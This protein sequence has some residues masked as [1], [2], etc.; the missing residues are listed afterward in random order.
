MNTNND[1]DTA[2]PNWFNQKLAD[3][4]PHVDDGCV[5][6]AFFEFSDE[7]TKVDPMQKTMGVV[8]NV[9]KLLKNPKKF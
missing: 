7:A 4:F 1:I 6:Y 9:T 8:G 3:L 5:G 2:I